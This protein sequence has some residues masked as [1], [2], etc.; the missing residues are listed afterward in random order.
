MRLDQRLGTI[1]TH[2]GGVPGYG[3]HMR[4]IPDRRIGV[5]ALSNVTYGDMRWACAEALEVLADL[6]A[7]PPAPTETATPALQ[8]AARPGGRRL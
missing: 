1:V 3:S 6:D 7:L 5:V 8:D 4:W 2:S